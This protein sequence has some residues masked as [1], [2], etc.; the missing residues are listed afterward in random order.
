MNLTPVFSSFWFKT[1][2]FWPK[3][4]VL[5]ASFQSIDSLALIGQNSL[6][7]SSPPILGHCPLQPFCSALSGYNVLQWLTDAIFFIISFDPP[8]A[9]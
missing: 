8:V 4:I 5:R 6:H 1:A 7:A 9:S 3:Q 2:L